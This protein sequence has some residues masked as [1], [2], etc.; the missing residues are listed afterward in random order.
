[1]PTRVISKD[2]K[3]R[4]PILFY[5]Q[6]RTVKEICL[7]LGIKKS[8]VYLA[9]SWFRSYGKPYNPDVHRIGRRRKLEHTDV[10][11]ICSLLKQRHCIYLDEIQEQLSTH[12][13]ITVSLSTL[14]H[15]LRTLHFSRKTVSAKALEQNLMDRLRCDF[16][17]TIF[18]VASWYSA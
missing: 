4:I 5:E 6:D 18:D 11:F 15:T 9:L 14:F 17:S 1:M 16:I 3:D 7:I 2:I 12:R 13:N 8:T 10:R